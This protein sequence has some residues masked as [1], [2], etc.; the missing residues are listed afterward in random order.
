[1]INIPKLRF[2]EFNEEWKEYRFEDFA[3]VIDGDR[4][5]NYPKSDEFYENEY[6]LFMSAK[7]VTKQGFSFKENQFITEEKDNKLSK[8]KLEREDIILTTRGSV[9][10]FALYTE[11][12][13]YDNIRINSGMVILRANDTVSKNFIY[14]ASFSPL[15][16]K[17]IDTIAFGSAQ[18]ALT[19][20]EIKKFKIKL[21]SKQ[22][23]EKIA[24]FLTSVDTKIEQLT[25]KEE[26]LQQYKKGVM[27]KIFSQEIRFKDDD[28]RKGTIKDFGHF[29]YGKGAP[30]TSVTN[31]AETPCVRYGE[32]YSTYEELIKTIKSY[33]NVNPKD[34]K[35]SKGGE[36]LVPR[37]GEDPLDFANCSYLPFEGVAIGEMI[38][39]YNTEE[40]GLYIAYY[41]NTMLKKQFA[42]VV[43]G[44]N[45]SN[46]YFKY[47]EDIELAIHS[48]D[49]QVKIVNFLQALDSKIEQ[50]QKQLN[51]TKEFKKALLQQ[52]FV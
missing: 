12:I 2:K 34:L 37:V 26:L 51:S 16:T 31:D 47:L 39:V 17:Q 9:G 11:D 29:Y 15:M 14:K 50:V 42:R 10:N 3:K 27:Q 36:V 7:N 22:E 4:G 5:V 33:T 19:V 30:K 48:K 20:K 38:S 25:S 28:I 41:F 21:P 18:P 13:P 49:E 40:N 46:L 44:G 52:M 35:F 43:E 24:S 23:Q 32:L 6:C 8:G 45:V 1:M